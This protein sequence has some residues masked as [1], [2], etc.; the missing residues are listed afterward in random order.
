MIPKKI[1]YCWFGHGKKSALVQ[2]CIESWKKYCPDYEI[3]EW[4]EDNF[5]VDCNG[6]TRFCY[7]NKL[8]AFLSDYVRLMAVFQHG[9]FYFDTDVEVLRSL[10]DLCDHQAFYGFE[11]SRHVAT[12]LAFGAEAGHITVKKL[13]EEYEPLLDGNGG[14]IGC[15]LLNTRALE[16]MGLLCNGMKQEIA[17]AVI[18]P[19]ECFNPYEDATGR[20]SI[21]ENTY[22]IHWYAKGWMDKRTIIRSKL[23]R[24][25][26]RWFGTDCFLWLKRLKQGKGKKV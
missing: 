26:H 23:T 16:K 14:V 3:I 17:G 18:Y 4:N 21:K 5:D 11:D 1:H 19:K 6:Y 7:E 22:S 2:K 24:P 10:D 20:L 12:G 13:L 9:G 15:P 25:F 8:W